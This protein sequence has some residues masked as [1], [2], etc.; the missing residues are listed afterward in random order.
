MAID[1]R[2]F[3]QGVLGASGAMAL[4]SAAGAN[5]LFGS[6]LAQNLPSPGQSDIEHIVIVTMENRSFD[7][8]LGWVPGANGKQAGLSYLDPN[9]VSHSTYALAPDWTGCGFNDPDHSYTGSRVCYDHGAMDGFL[10]DTANDVFCIGYYHPQDIPFY[11]GLAA[12]YTVCSNYFASILGPTFPNRL[13]LYAA[14]T[15]RLTDSITLTNLPTIL[16]SLDQAGVS[17]RY[18]FNN[19]PFTA[20]WGARYLLKSRPYAEF[21][22]EASLGLLPSVAFID[23]AFTITDDGT[24]TDDHPHDD[25]RRGDAFLSQ[26]FYAIAKSPNWKNTVLIVNFDEWGGFFEHVAPP[27]A[28][29]PNDVDPDQVNGKTLL[30][31]RVPTVVVSPWSRGTPQHIRVDTNTYDHTSALKLIESRW[32][33]PPLTKRDASNDIANLVNALDFSNP[34]YAIPKLAKPV[35]PPPHPCISKVKRQTEWG[36]LMNSDLTRG[37][38]L[39]R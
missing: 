38:N 37:W 14:Q 28:E 34:N 6:T 36:A 39:P 31:F 26:T 25:I 30:G 17:A 33:L 2:K 1:R 22:L 27:R 10:L 12:N 35:M 4:G 18:Y 11:A 20:L 16:D 8:F 29:A 9:G 24:G 23:P 13:F 21:L 3:L 7:H 19:V 32:G 5:K 15:D